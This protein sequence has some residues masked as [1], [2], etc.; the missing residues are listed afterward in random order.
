MNDTT[1]SQQ[2]FD[3]G[4]ERGLSEALTVINRLDAHTV[5]F[6][7]AGAIKKDLLRDL[8][9]ELKKKEKTQ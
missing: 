6:A 2:A 8:K 7:I 4:Y 3:M 5:L 9:E 1:N